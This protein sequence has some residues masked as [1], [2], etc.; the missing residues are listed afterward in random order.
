MHRLLLTLSFLDSGI[1]LWT[2]CVVVFIIW[3]VNEFL[4]WICYSYTFGD[5]ICKWSLATRCS[6]SKNCVVLSQNQQKIIVKMWSVV[7]II[8]NLMGL[9]KFTQ[10]FPIFIVFRFIACIMQK[11]FLSISFYGGIIYTILIFV[12]N[13]IKL[14]LQYIASALKPC[15]GKVHSYKEISFLVDVLNISSYSYLKW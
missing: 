3:E 1:H 9:G 4:C 7:G 11:Q 13:Y 14:Y 15:I 6:T 10:S 2:F 5:T 12:S 8:S